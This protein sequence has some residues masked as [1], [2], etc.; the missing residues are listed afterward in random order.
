MSVKT[1]SSGSGIGIFSDST[2]IGDVTRAGSA[3]FN[4]TNGEYA[5]TGGGANM[6]DA[7]DGFHFVW[8][9]MSGDLTLTADVK[10][11]GTGGVDHRKACLMIRQSLASNSAYADVALHGDGMTSLQFREAEGEPTDQIVMEVSGPE[12]VQIQK[13]GDEVTIACAKA[14]GQWRQGGARYRIQFKEPFYVGL[15]VCAHDNDRIEQAIFSNVE[16]KTISAG[17]LPS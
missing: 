9:K 1:V 2:D 11:V 4:S 3:S 10:L 15:G 8:V 14:G 17:T 5:V 7:S 13:R 12:R 16:L 6:W